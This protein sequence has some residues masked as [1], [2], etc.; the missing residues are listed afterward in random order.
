MP[1][2]K[3]KFAE[4]VSDWRRRAHFSETDMARALD[5]GSAEA[6]VALERGTRR[7]DGHTLVRF[8][9]LV[10]VDWEAYLRR[11][12]KLDPAAPW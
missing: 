11:I 4:A 7:P 12:K 9:H 8:R 2:R 6:Y 1:S 5:L 3:P 10:G